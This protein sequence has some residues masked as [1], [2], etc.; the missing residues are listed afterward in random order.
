MSGYDFNEC[1]IDLA[2]VPTSFVLLTIYA[3]VKLLN[4]V[5]DNYVH[6]LVQNKSDGKLVAF[7]GEREVNHV[8][9]SYHQSFCPQIKIFKV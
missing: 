9:V 1:G 4:V 5:L 6:R 3:C 2:V 7:D 8:L